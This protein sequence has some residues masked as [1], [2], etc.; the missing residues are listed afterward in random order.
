MEPTHINTFSHAVNH[1]HIM[2][3]SNELII[4]SMEEHFYS[5]TLAYGVYR[6]NLQARQ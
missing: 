6:Q 5:L 4:F 2:H 3:L 1:A